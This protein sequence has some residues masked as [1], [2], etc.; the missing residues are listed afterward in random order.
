M[1][2]F[3]MQA[4]VDAILGL[5]ESFGESTG[6]PHNILEHSILVAQLA[7]EEGYDDEVILAAFFH[8][9]G[10]LLPNHSSNS[11][12]SY[13]Q[14]GSDYLRANGFSEKVVQVVIMQTE[15][16]R[17]LAW[18]FP[19]RKFESPFSFPTYP[20]VMS[21]KEAKAYEKNPY[22]FLSLKVN[23]WDVSTLNTQAVCVNLDHYR[24]IALRHLQGNL[25]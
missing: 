4:T 8:D 10:Y 19:E 18:K 15:A 11:R 1:K 21:E 7:E 24:T 16:Q 2:N 23:E 14:I 5:Y 22:F 20:E 25:S 3:E 17:Y 12:R 9:I 6:E 13:G